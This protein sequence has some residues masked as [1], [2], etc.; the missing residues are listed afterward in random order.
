M[1]MSTPSSYTVMMMPSKASCRM[2]GCD[3]ADYG[4][5][6]CARLHNI[7]QLLKHTTTT[8]ANV[9]SPSLPIASLAT[10]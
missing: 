7:T 4:D 10:M 5:N 2:T 3:A 8:N 6:K 9:S 1:T